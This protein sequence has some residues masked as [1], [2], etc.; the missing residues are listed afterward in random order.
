MSRKKDRSISRHG[1]SVP[2]G[3][4]GNLPTTNESRT[5]LE[6]DVG[7]WRI[8]VISDKQAYPEFISSNEFSRFPGRASST[9][10]RFQE[11][12]V[13]SQPR[14]LF[15]PQGV[16][17]GLDLLTSECQLL[18]GGCHLFLSESHLFT[19]E[20]QL[21]ISGTGGDSGRIGSLFGSSGASSSFN[22]ALINGSKR[23]TGY[24]YTTGDS[25]QGHAFD[26]QPNPIMKYVAL[27]V[28]LVIGMRGWFRLNLTDK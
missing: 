18:A 16:A 1:N 8:S 17:V 26:C 25:E 10:S 20:L 28:R 9:R 15:E 27:I 7:R 3:F 24:D 21:F 14:S 12:P 19:R 2:L 23:V 11:V 5:T 6:C 13:V 4:F 22:N